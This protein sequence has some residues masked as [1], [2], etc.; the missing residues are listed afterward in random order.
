[1]NLCRQVGRIPSQV[2]LIGIGNAVDIALD[3]EFAEERCLS[4]DKHEASESL[5]NSHVVFFPMSSKYLVHGR[6]AHRGDRGSF[7]ACVSIVIPLATESLWKQSN[8]GGGTC[9]PMLRR[10]HRSLVQRYAEV[11]ADTCL[12]YIIFIAISP[13]WHHKLIR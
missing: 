9:R 11:P 8:Q 5:M 4:T 12:T 13:K 1:M 3:P 2:R 7:L 10:R 6:C